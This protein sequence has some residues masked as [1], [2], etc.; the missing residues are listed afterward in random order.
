MFKIIQW[1]ISVNIVEIG[2]HLEKGQ[3]GLIVLMGKDKIMYLIQF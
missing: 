2:G 1:E 3:S